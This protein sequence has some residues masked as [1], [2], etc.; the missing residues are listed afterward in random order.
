M[1]QDM[2][3]RQSSDR[4]ACYEILSAARTDEVVTYDRLSAACMRDVQAHRGGLNA[5]RR[6]LEREGKIFAVIRGVGLRLRTNEEGVSQARGDVSAIRR[7]AKRGLL[8]ASH[9]DTSALTSEQT[10]EHCGLAAVLADA[11]R[12]VSQRSIAASKQKAID[13]SRQVSIPDGLEVSK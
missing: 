5:A 9:V 2:T 8:R 10:I 3:G 1:K 4:I 13:S 6:Q 12:A 11:G 7:R